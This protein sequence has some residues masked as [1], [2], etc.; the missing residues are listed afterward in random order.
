[1]TIT[2]TGNI[3]L[4][5]LKLVDHVAASETF[6][7]ACGVTTAD[8]AKAFIH[9]PWVNFGTTI[10]PFAGIAQAKDYVEMRAFGGARTVHLP[11]GAF[12]LMLAIDDDPNL[13]EKDNFIRVDNFASGV[14][15]D[16]KDIS[17]V[18]DNLNMTG[19][20]L[21]QEHAI[22]EPT[23]TI[24]PQFTAEANPRFWLVGY[25]VLWGAI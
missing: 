16:L 15:A 25:R 21:F 11:T 8:A 2:A 17:G 22:S 6:Q 19:F 5:M 24:D 1:M 7:T 18:S 10:R 9:W 20:E 13:D 3:G 14:I 12:N 4:G 23:T